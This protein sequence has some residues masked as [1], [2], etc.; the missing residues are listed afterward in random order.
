MVASYAIFPLAP[1]IWLAALLALCAHLG[2]GSQWTLSTYGLQRNTPDAIRGRIFSL[3][4]GLVTLTIAGSTLLA[5]FIA[6]ALP[7]RF[8]VWTMVGLIGVAG[9]GWT[10]LSRT[11]DHVDTTMPVDP[12]VAD[13]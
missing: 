12:R 1:G 5:G 2:S 3:D 4:Y 10:L 8:A 9:I 13:D 11:V 7:P 6:E